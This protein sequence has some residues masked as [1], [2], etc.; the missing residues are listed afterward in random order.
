MIQF[1]VLFWEKKGIKIRKSKK[2]FS[3]E[4]QFYNCQLSTVINLMRRQLD[5]YGDLITIVVGKYNE[6]S[7]GGHM[8]LDAMASSRAAMMERRT[9]MASHEV[10]M[11]KGVIQG[12]LRRQLSVVNLRASMACMLDRLHQC[13]EGG[14]LRNRRQEWRVREEERM[15]EEREM[16]WATRMIGRSLLQPGRI[17]VN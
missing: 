12:E 6:L 16:Q 1:K 14:R 13:G 8:L 10:K 17:I 11:E 4:T 5:R 15:R 7:E 9:G 3:F 2:I